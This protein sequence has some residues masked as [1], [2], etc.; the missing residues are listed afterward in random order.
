MNRSRM[1][2][3][4]VVLAAAGLAVAQDVPFEGVVVQ[5]DVQVRCGAG[6]RYYVVGTVAKGARVR[7]EE[8]FY[9]WN[10]IV[11]PQDVYS[12]ISKAYVDAKGDGKL[13]QVTADSQKV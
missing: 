8:V 9:G 4:L 1:I 13:G 6:M 11:P 10:K 7:V 12:Y 3:A 2:V 5:D